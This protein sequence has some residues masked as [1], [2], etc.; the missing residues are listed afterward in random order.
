MIQK[1][2]KRHS[3]FR[4]KE[5]FNKNLDVVSVCV[6]TIFINIYKTRKQRKIYRFLRIV[7]NKKLLKLELSINSPLKLKIMYKHKLIELYICPGNL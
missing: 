7:H 3:S 1:T 5:N 6:I 4:K 2:P